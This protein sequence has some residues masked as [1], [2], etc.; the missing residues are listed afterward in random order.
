MAIGTAFAGVVTADIATAKAW[1]ERLFGRPPDML[2]HDRE[3]C[4]QLVGDAWFYVVEDGMEAGKG[5]LTLLV[6]DLDDVV[7]GPACSRPGPGRDRV[8][9]HGRPQVARRRS[10]GHENRLR[11][12]RRRVAACA[13]R[14][15]RVRGV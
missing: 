3:A 12:A 10:G 14:A 15:S 6:D 2:P 13:F 4:W 8:G 1:Y 7:A 5:L 9:R 11:P